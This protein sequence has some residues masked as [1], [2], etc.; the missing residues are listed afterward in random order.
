MGIG[1]WDRESKNILMHERGG[2]V[3]RILLNKRYIAKL[4]SKWTSIF[5]AILGFIGTFASLSDLLPDNSSIQHRIFISIGIMVGLWLILFVAFSGYVFWKRR[6]ELFEASNG[7]HVYVQY[8]DVFSAEEVLKPEERRNIVIP[9]NRCFDTM[10]DDDLISS[11]TLHGITMKKMYASGEYTEQTLNKAIQENLSVQKSEYEQ[12]R[13]ED[14]RSGNLNRYSVGTVAEVRHTDNC[15][16][17]FLGLSKF[18]RDLH[19]HTTNDE[20]VLALMRLLEFCNIRSQKYAVVMPLIG[21]GASETKKSERDIL[22]YLVKLLKM[23]KDLI[24]SDIHIVVRDSGK[25]SIAI[26]DI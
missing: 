22:E 9:V 2:T 20:Y 19:A 12:I 8:G 18:D 11:N 26:T 4:A 5:F 25:E 24:N 21:A 10:V 16:Y 15:T 14:K 6:I 1:L 13:R 7:Y 23:N 17:F 3:K